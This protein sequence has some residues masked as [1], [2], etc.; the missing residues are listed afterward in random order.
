MLLENCIVPSLGD[1][2]GVNPF[3]PEAVWNRQNSKTE[4]EEMTSA[5]SGDLSAAVSYFR[6]LVL[7]PAEAAAYQPE[8]QACGEQNP[9]V[10]TKGELEGV[11]GE[12]GAHRQDADY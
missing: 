11:G 12:Y 3:C 5:C 6:N 7:T 8:N 4:T 9:N 10:G 2:T 1:H